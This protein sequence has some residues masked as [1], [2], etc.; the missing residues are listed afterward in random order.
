MR[1]ALLAACCN[2]RGCEGGQQHRMHTHMK[3][4]TVEGLHLPSRLA[5]AIKALAALA[6][7]SVMHESHTY[8]HT[9]STHLRSCTR[10]M[11]SVCG[12][13]FAACVDALRFQVR[14]AALRGL[15]TLLGP[16][17]LSFSRHYYLMLEV[18]HR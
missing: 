6:K 16:N 1:A 8:A 3:C 4:R 14:E 13:Q 17:R 7:S 10:T 5:H 2:F 11:A 15:V 12:C 9:R 18:G